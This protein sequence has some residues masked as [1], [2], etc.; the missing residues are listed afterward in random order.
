MDNQSN[1]QTVNQYKT[2]SS[3]CFINQQVNQVDKLPKESDLVLY[4]AAKEKCANKQNERQQTPLF[5]VTSLITNAP[6]LHKPTVKTTQ[7]SNQATN[8]FDFSENRKEQVFKPHCI[9][10]AEPGNNSDTVYR[11]QLKTSNLPSRDNLS[12]NPIT[13]GDSKSEYLRTTKTPL[14]KDQ[15]SFN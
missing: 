3:K 9:K 4:Q 5:Q 2:S 8:I 15:F 12:R 1:F 10:I 7:Y 11:Q 6:P 14:P 13:T